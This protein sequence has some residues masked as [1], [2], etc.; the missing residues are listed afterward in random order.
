MRW[1]W[2]RASSGE[3]L[4]VSWSGQTLVYLLATGAG[5]DFTVIRSGV[6]LQGTDSLDEFSYRLVQLGLKGYVTDVMLRP[7]QYQLLQIEAPAVAPEELR[8]AARYQIKEM[9]DVHLDDL[10]IDVLKVGD[11]RGRAASQL[12]VVAANNAV[13]RDAMAL[14]ER[15]AVGRSRDRCAGHGPA[16]SPK[17]RRAGA[18]HLRAH[19]FGRPADT[20][21]HQR[22]QRVVLQPSPRLAGW[23]YGHDLDRSSYGTA[24]PCWMPTR[25]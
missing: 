1:P 5:D 21:H 19:G 25:R 10:T 17:H 22:R 4:V 23:L 7:E 9:V 13:V 8:S 18:R 16:R 3:R 6:E 15:I 2:R 20:A 24:G 12:F 11:G 14:A